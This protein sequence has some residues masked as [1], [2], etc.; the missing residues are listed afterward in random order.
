MGEAPK[1]QGITLFRNLSRN[2]LHFSSPFLHLPCGI[3]PGDIQ[4]FKGMELTSLNLFFCDK[5]T[6]VFGLGW[7]W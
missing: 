2:L 3:T 4:V 6:G 7:V 1:Q 5:L